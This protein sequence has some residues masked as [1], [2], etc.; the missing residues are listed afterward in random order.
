MALIRNSIVMIFG[1]DAGIAYSAIMKRLFGV[2]VGGG[3][4]MSV[5]AAESAAIREI[6]GIVKQNQ[7]RSDQLKETIQRI[8]GD[9]STSI[10]ARRSTARPLAAELKAIDGI[11]PQLSERLEAA[12]DNYQSVEQQL[13][14]AEQTLNEMKA[15]QRANEA[16]ARV[17]ATLERANEALKQ[18]SNDHQRVFQQATEGIKRAGTT[19]DSV[20]TARLSVGAS[21]RA[22]ESA[23]VDSYLDSF[24]PAGNLPAGE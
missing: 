19:T 11:L 21:N 22:A 7:D 3:G 13:R 16:T 14:Q 5:A 23:S 20:R 24:V 10:V 17:N 2:V 8:M 18:T 6:A 12:R 9:T 1:E 4:Q 15:Q